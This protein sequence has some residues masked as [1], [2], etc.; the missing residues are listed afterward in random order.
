ML[1]EMAEVVYDAKQFGKR[2][3]KLRKSRKITQEELAE[4]LFLS[5][6]TISNIENGKTTC[7]P[8]HLTKICQI[9]NV[10][11]DYFYFDMMKELNNPSNTDM[12]SIMALLEG[13]SE[14]DITRAK[15][16]LQILFAS[17]AA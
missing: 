7:M 9:F 8:E 6:D 1:A 12:D 16:M 11:A 4:K 15:Q 14:F 3:Q 5:E 2:L 10:S 17:P 13:R